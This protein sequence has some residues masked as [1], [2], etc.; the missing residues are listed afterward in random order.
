MESITTRFA[1]IDAEQLHN[2]IG[3]RV[4]LVLALFGLIDPGLVDF[5]FGD[6]D[7]MTERVAGSVPHM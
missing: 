5:H 4:I 3:G 6:D 1:P 2:Q 7:A